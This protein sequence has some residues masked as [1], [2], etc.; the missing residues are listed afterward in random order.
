MERYKFI[1]YYEDERIT[2]NPKESR[3]TKIPNWEA[4]VIEKL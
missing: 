1:T 3:K 2:M 4:A